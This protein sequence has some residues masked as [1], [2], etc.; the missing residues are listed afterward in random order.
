MATRRSRCQLEVTSKSSKEGEI[1][2][3]T[4]HPWTSIRPTSTGL[5]RR[6]MG[7]ENQ[8]MRRMEVVARQNPIRA[9]NERKKKMKG[10][11]GLNLTVSS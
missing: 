9:L 11:Y 4:S 10:P 7:D 3:V 2:G 8:G 6:E 5:D 1:V